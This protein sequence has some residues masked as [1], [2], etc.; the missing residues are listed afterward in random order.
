MNYEIKDIDKIV[1]YKTWTNKKKVDTLLEI[2]A[3]MYCELGLGT[4]LSEKKNAKRNS[5]KIYY[6]IKKV[7]SELGSKLI[8]S[9]D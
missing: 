9:M 5:R 6:A 2:D 3:N 1:E 7:D 8:Q 4:P